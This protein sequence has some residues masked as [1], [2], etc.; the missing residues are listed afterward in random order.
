[1]ALAVSPHETQKNTDLVSKLGVQTTSSGRAQ[2]LWFFNAPQPGGSRRDAMMLKG[3][4][5]IL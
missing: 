3:D 1:M 4:S 2:A 5:K